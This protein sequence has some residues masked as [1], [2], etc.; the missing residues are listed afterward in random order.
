MTAGVEFEKPAI[1][2]DRRR[3]AVLEQG[4]AEAEQALLDLKAAWEMEDEGRRAQRAHILEAH[5]QGARDRDAVRVQL[6]GESLL[7]QPEKAPE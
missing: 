6:G 5:A 2:P 7:A 1:V 3:L 4:H